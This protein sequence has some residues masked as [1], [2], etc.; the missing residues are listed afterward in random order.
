LG[1]WNHKKK[2][3]YCLEKETKGRKNVLMC[4]DMD[5]GQKEVGGGDLRVSK[6]TPDNK[7]I[8]LVS[9]NDQSEKNQ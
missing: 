9:K 4:T 2:S 8:G 6:R 3:R 1:K 5:R 7:S